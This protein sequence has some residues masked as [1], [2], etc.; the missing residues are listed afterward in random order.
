MTH[1][2]CKIITDCILEIFEE[3]FT[4]NKDTINIE[5][6]NFGVLEIFAEKNIISVSAFIFVLSHLGLDYSAKEFSQQILNFFSANISK[7]RN[8]KNSKIDK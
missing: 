1:N 7:I 8:F 3:M 2:D 5:L 6:R 4:E